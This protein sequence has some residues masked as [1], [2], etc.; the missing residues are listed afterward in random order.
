LRRRPGLVDDLAGLLRCVL[1]AALVLA[2]TTFF[3]REY[4]FSRTFLVGFAAASY[5]FLLAGRAFSRYLHLL[6]RE[7]GIGVERVAILGRGPMQGRLVRALHGRAGIGY[8][9]AGEILQPE[10]APGALPALGV[11]T[12]LQDAVERHRIDLVLVAAPFHAVG[13]M[14]PVLDALAEHQVRV[15]F[16]PDLEEILA[17]SLRVRNIEGLPLLELRQVALTGIDRVAKRTFDLVIAALM[18][19]CLSPLLLLIAV[20]VRLGSPGP[21]L[22]RQQRVGRDGRIFHILKYRTMRRDAEHHTGPVFAHAADPRRTRFGTWLRTFSLDELPQLWNVLR[23]DM[24]LVGPRPE[25][26]V[27]VQE[28]R[29]TIPR[30]FERHKMR[31]GITGWA[32][33]NGLRGDTPL[34]ERTRYDL[35]YVENWSLAFDLKI[36]ALTL[37]SVVSRRNAY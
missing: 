2:A 13:Q 22:Y 10:E 5:A 15:L 16:L 30:Y 32:Q 14:L 36:L 21:T 28:F 6:A 35:Y 12:E 29:S 25:R 24:S 1:Q 11:A 27:F 37:R 7:R 31:S 33:V 9:L 19:V 17:T 4:S 20:G 8:V 23:G 3:Y 26:P 18:L 34:E